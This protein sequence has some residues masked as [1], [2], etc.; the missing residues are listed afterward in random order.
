MEDIMKI[1]KTMLLMTVAA[2]AFAHSQDCG[3]FVRGQ[4]GASQGLQLKRDSVLSSSRTKSNNFGVYGGVGLET[5]T[6]LR[7]HHEK[8]VG[9]L[10][11]D[12]NLESTKYKQK[13]TP[14]AATNTTTLTTEAKRQVVVNALGQLG[15][16]VKQSLMPYVVA[17]ASYAQFKFS[18]TLKTTGRSTVYAAGKTKNILG[19]AGGAGLSWSVNHKW[20]TDVRYL[21]TA[22]GNTKTSTQLGLVKNITK[23]P[24]AYHAVTL[25]V[26]YKI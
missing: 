25:G 10:G 12:V 24:S 3:I 17:G 4:I 1:V 6:P 21:Y 7:N 20:S 9:G 19:W 16:K 18:N 13:G 2:G 8:L 22:Y 15:W 11:V 14:A 26:S 23:A 5:R